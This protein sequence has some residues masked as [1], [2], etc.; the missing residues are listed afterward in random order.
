MKKVLEI[1]LILI[2][3]LTLI[4][5]SHDDTEEINEPIQKA[6]DTVGDVLDPVADVVDDTVDVVNDGLEE[7]TSGGGDSSTEDISISSSASDNAT[8]AFG[9][10]YQYQV[11]TSG[12]YS[13][14]IT[15]SLSNQPDGMTISSSGLVEWTPT[16]ASDIKTHSNITISLTTASGYVLTEAYDLTV[17]GTCTTGNVLSIWSGDQR[18][19]T[20][21]TKFLGNITAYT[22]NASSVKTAS[23]NYNYSSSSVDLTHGPQATVNDGAMFFYNQYDNTTHNYLFYFFGMDVGGSTNSVS[24]DLFVANNAS[25]D[26]N[27]V[28]DDDGE[29]DRVSQSQSATTGL[30]ASSYTGRY[31][32]GANSDGAVIGPFSNTDNQ[33][34]LDNGT[35]FK[36]F[37][38]LAGT[39]SLLTSV[40]TNRS[41][42]LTLGDLDSMKYYSKDNSTIVLG[43][44]D[45]FTIGYN[46]TIT[47]E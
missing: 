3:G 28:D 14:T 15:Y 4:S 33:T 26:S 2:F 44:H 39:S 30:W 10:S 47:C 35:T 37:V 7:V 18:T 25:Q 1:I 12:T 13:G 5:C 11:T 27:P 40:P 8:V 21:S 34:L 43:D 31:R 41:L 19:S 23:Q 24:I 17:T 32:Y 6:G 46:T 22:D 38:D 16:K 29:T 20:D 36:I 9:Q 42:A 45:N